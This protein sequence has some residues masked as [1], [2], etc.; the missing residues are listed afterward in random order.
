MSQPESPFCFTVEG[1]GEGIQKRYTISRRMAA[2]CKT[3]QLLLEEMFAVC[4]DPSFAPV[5]PG[6]QEIHMD[7]LVEYLLQF[8]AAVRTTIDYQD[9]GEEPWQLEFAHSLSNNNLM[10]LMV[11]SDFVEFPSLTDLCAKEFIRRIEG[12]TDLEI[13]RSFHISNDLTSDERKEIELE[14]RMWYSAQP[15]QMV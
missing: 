12:K 14:N 10:G 3:L 11:A 7:L 1:A 9:T 2:H 8:D 4:D 13:R 15:S 6:I 5:L